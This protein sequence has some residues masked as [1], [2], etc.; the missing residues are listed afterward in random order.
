MKYR[1]ILAGLP[2]F[3]ATAGVCVGYFTCYASVAIQSSMAWRVPYLVQIALSVV[4][5]ASCIV[6]P[7]SPRWLM[8]H[9]RRAEALKSLHRLD[10]SMVEAERD[11]LTATEQRPSLS[12]WQNFTLLFRKGYR[13][14]TILALFVLGMVQLSGIDGVLY[15]GSLSSVS[16][17]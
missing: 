4:L 11:F 16:E 7:D 15:V 10:F 1:G 14:R 9:G 8:L 13:A 2:Q 5:V 6:L 12:F 3:M 17:A